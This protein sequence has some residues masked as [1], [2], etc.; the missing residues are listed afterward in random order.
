MEAPDGDAA[1]NSLL[2]FPNNLVLP[3][4]NFRLS[5]ILTTV[6]IAP[7]IVFG[8]PTNSLNFSGIF[9]NASPFSVT[10]RIV[11]GATGFTAPIA[12]E[13]INVSGTWEKA[14]GLGSY[15]TLT[16]YIDPSNAQ[17]AETPT[18]TPGTV[19]TTFQNASATVGTENF[20][21]TGDFT[22]VHT[23]AFSMT[24]ALDFTLTPGARLTVFAQEL[25]FVGNPTQVP[26]P[27]PASLAL[28]GLGFAGLG[29]SRRRR[30]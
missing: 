24:M 6:V 13:Q 2:N 18:D 17:G 11:V 26:V 27:E 15:V 9:S 1:L 12:T 23:S 20:I 3:S 21:T 4:N 22:Q 16:W 5:D 28:L 29:L 8:T 25:A 30:T 19:L 7:P 10:G 14:N